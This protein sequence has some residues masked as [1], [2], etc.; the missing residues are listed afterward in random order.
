M[1]NECLMKTMFN[2]LNLQEAFDAVKRNKGSAG[3]D[4]RSITE[5]ELHW[6]QHGAEIEAKLKAG[7]YVPSPVLGVKIPKSDGGERL[8]GIPT[9]QDRVIQQAIQQILTPLFDSGF[10]SSSY[11]YRPYLSAHHAIKQAQAY[12]QEGKTW[13]VDIDISAFF[14]EVN[15]DILLHL[16]SQKVTDHEVLSLIR[17]YLKTGIMLAGKVECRHKGVPQGSPLS[18]L[19]ANIYLDKLDKELEKRGL[20]FCRY[21][22]DVAIFVSSERSAQRVLES[23]SLWIVKHLNLRVNQNKSGAGRPWDGQ[24]LGFRITEE[25]EIVIAPKSI[26]RY[27]EKVRKCWDARQS[28]TSKQLIKQ[29]RQYSIGWWSYF[30]I[31]TE[32][33][34][35]K[36]LEGWTRRHMRKCF[37]L[38]WHN[39]KGRLNAL[40]R[41]GATPRQ[42]ETASSSRGAWR[43]AKSPT[44]HKV[45]SNAT[46]RRYGLF[47]PSELTT[48]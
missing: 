25:A 36:R 47:A 24:Y 35:I 30:K 5:T 39:K 15:H 28:L 18:P 23:I 37:W 32:P 19:L 27:Q 21:A 11:G 3:I 46:L 38:R 13:V 48:A 2:W 8:L 33:W 20:S 43:I 7:T 40:R 42:Q 41:L 31:A 9:V 29:W 34:N 26:A 1:I 22:D 10:S 4:G 17:K 16:I 14:D 6:Q 45:L 44:L 12:V